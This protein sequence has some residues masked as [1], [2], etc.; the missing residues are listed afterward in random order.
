MDFKLVNTVPRQPTGVPQH[1]AAAKPSKSQALPG[2][3]PTVRIFDLNERIKRRQQMVGLA[4]IGVHDPEISR[5]DN[6]NVLAVWV[7][8]SKIQPIESRLEV[9]DPASGSRHEF[10]DLALAR[11]TP[12]LR[13]KG[14]G[15]RAAGWQSCQFLESKTHASSSG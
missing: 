2:E 14:C 12:P 4:P 13:R 3:N 1:A 15:K 5:G 6:D 11:K 9:A 8:E 7:Q 10:D